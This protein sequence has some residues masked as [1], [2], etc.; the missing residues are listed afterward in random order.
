VRGYKRKPNVEFGQC[1]ADRRVDEV[2]LTLIGSRERAV[3]E[4]VRERGSESER[5]REGEER[6]KIGWVYKRG[7]CKAVTT[8][9]GTGAIGNR[10]QLSTCI[11]YL[12]SSFYLPPATSLL[13]FIS[14]CLSPSPPL[15]PAYPARCFSNQHVSLSCTS[16]IHPDTTVCRTSLS[17]RRTPTTLLTSRAQN[18]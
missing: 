2:A 6:R 14:V 1:L 17:P 16:C 18:T 13:V 5:Y 11:N 12:L 4:I 7:D 15:L 3:T 10:L 9:L 8:E